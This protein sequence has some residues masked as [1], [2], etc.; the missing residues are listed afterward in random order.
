MP[1]SATVSHEVGRPRHLRLNSVENTQLAMLMKQGL[2]LSLVGTIYVR[3]E[4]FIVYWH[5]S[6][7]GARGFRFIWPQKIR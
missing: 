7:C 3:Q 2:S 5:N 4:G 6:K 1:D